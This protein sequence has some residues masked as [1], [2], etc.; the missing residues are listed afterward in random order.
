[1][2][3]TISDW[4]ILLVSAVGSIALIWSSLRYLLSRREPQ[5][6]EARMYPAEVVL[7]LVLGVIFL[8]IV[9]ILAV[10]L[11]FGSDIYGKFTDDILLGVAAASIIE[12][13]L[14]V[15]A[16]VLAAIRLRRNKR[17]IQ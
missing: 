3:G 8:P 7:R 4:V 10:A 9:G 13:I 1:M 6:A 15:V 11:L 2:A 16:L 12:L 14:A 17:H 5:R